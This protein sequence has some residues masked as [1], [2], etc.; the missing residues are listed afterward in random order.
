MQNL[1]RKLIIFN[2]EIIY[3]IKRLCQGLVYFLG[4]R[5]VEKTG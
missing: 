1:E 4:I 3:L 2:H 5:K